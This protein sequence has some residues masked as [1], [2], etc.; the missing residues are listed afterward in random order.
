[1]TTPKKMSA[2]TAI[3]NPA[4]GTPDKPVKRVLLY[5][6]R[7]KTQTLKLE[8]RELAK[9]EPGTTWGWVSSSAE[10]KLKP[11]TL[12]NP[13][14]LVSLAADDYVSQMRDLTHRIDN[15]GK[16]LTQRGNLGARLW[17]SER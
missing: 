13:S 1:M 9:S 14:T 15:A 10:E 6:T 2:V 12:A 3:I 4:T 17:R 16:S 5:T 7:S 8:Q 11:P